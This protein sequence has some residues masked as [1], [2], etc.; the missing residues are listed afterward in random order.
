MISQKRLETTLHKIASF[1]TPHTGKGIYRLA[2][3]DSDQTCRQF[4]TGL[5]QDA[6]LQIRTDAFGN[7]IG[8]LDGKDGSLP[9]IMFGSHSDSVPAGGNYDGIV[10][11]LAAIETVKSMQEDHF[12]PDSPLEIVLFQCEESSRFGAAT[13]GSK[14]MRGKL[15]ADDLHQ[16]H[17]QAGSSLYDVLQQRGLA[18]DH[19][20]QARYTNPLKSFFEVHIEQG[21]VLEHEHL[22]IGIV[23][24]IAAPTRMIVT[25]NGNADHSGATPMSLRH[26]GMCA[27]AEVILAV[28]AA[29][30]KHTDPPVVGTVGIVHVHPDAMNVIPGTV[31]LGIDIRSIAATAKNAAIKQIQDNIATICH[32]RMIPFTIN[33]LCNE[34]PV[35]LPTTM[36]SFLE[37]ICQAQGLSCL[38]MPSGAGHDAMHWAD[39]TPTGMLFIPCRHGISHNPA[40]YASIEDIV[41]VTRLLEKTIRTVSQKTFHF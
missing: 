40:E 9:A 26:D 21:K 10:G 6:G 22:D 28:E 39:Y 16:L 13:L 5:L 15:T 29:A 1:S 27:A 33:T 3:T 23:T 24:G 37:K 34:V 2:F 8:H 19:L 35:P 17:D 7:I 20:E 32:K 18:P 25:L 12:Q 36:T 14:A 30:S 38:K 31:E 4:L 41:S 11:I